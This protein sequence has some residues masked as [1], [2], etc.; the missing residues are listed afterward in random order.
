MTDQ[1]HRLQ[2][3]TIKDVARRA[4]VSLKTVSRVINNEPNVQ[5]RT[6][7]RVQR[8]VEELDY[9][10][11]LSA[12]STRSRVRACTFGSSLMTRETVFSDTLAR[13][14]TSFI[15]LRCPRWL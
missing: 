11:D 13:L 8:A 6:R 15:V 7:E 12:R 1:S 2:R 14:A 4:K 3:S 10:P 5:A 9:R